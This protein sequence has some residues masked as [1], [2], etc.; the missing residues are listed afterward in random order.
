ME[1]CR[2]GLWHL[3]SQY[4]SHVRVNEAGELIYRFDSLRRLRRSSRLVMAWQRLYSRLAKVGE[5]ALAVLTLML[6]P[7]FLL[8]VAGHAWAFSEVTPGVLGA[9]VMVVMGGFYL[10]GI[11]CLMLFQV[12]PLAIGVS[13]A[14]GIIMI[15]YPF[16]HGDDFPLA[17]FP[18]VLGLMLLGVAYM[19]AL[20]TWQLWQETLAGNRAQ[21]ARKLWRQIGGALFGPVALPD[22]LRDERRLTALI[23]REAGV[24]TAADLVALFGWTLDQADS[25]LTRILADY[26]GDVIVSQEGAIVYRFDAMR[27]RCGGQGNED[28]RPI[29]ER[30]HAPAP[31]WDCPPT[32]W[33]LLLVAAVLGLMGLW[34]HPDLVLFPNA[35]Q[36]AEGVEEVFAKHREPIFMQG[37]GAYLYVAAL[38]PIGVRAIWRLI[39]RLRVVRKRRFWRVLRAAVEHPMGSYPVA[40]ANRDVALLGGTWDVEKTNNQGQPLLTF[41][42]IA[43]AGRAAQEARRSV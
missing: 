5:P 40:V 12:L 34:L 2:D 26:G 3:C 24:L 27:V 28:L 39:G 30:D 16:E 42:A 7:P 13:I 9:I 43:A 8:S 38:L 4:P 11:I 33:I 31:F 20:W 25:E 18:I 15:A 37:A 10:S 14:G 21:W 36:L 17:L 32:T 1:Q 35:K 22:S 6:L 23:E 19:F 29:Y 41:P